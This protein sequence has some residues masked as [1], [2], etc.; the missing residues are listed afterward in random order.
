MP[1]KLLAGTGGSGWL[2]A[3]WLGRQLAGCWPGVGWLA[4]GCWLAGWLAAG[5]LA[6]GWLA[7]GW[8]EWSPQLPH[9]CQGVLETPYRRS[10]GSERTRAK[11]KLGLSSLLIEFIILD[12]SKKPSQ[13]RCCHARF[14]AWRSFQALRILPSR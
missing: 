3:G 9:R 1:S 7:A 12:F 4:A 6:A 10:E 5:W 8:L 2:L 14:Y 13:V 11:R